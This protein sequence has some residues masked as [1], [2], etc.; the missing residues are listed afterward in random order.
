[1]EGA[2]IA[3]YLELFAKSLGC[4]R[5]PSLPA[6]PCRAAFIQVP[7]E[8]GT[9]DPKVLGD[10]FAGVTVGLHPVCGGDVLRIVHLPRPTE[11]GAVGARNGSDQF[12]SQLGCAPEVAYKLAQ[13]WP[14]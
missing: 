14:G 13:A 8:G 3:I 10:V 4:R 12:L 2:V 5:A 1:M 6:A 11:L 9:T 7:V